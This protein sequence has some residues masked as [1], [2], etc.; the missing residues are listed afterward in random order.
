M[1]IP[2][3]D[4]LRSAENS[5]IRLEVIKGATVW[6]TSPVF[7]HQQT[8]KRI[9]ASLEPLPDSSC[10]CIETQDTYFKFPDGSLKRPDIAILCAVPPLEVQNDPLEIIPAAVVEVI[11]KIT[12]TSIIG[13]TKKMKIKAIRLGAILFSMLVTT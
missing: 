13:L 2:F 12:N 1:P 9:V 11:S 6:E 4:A 5:N 10:A 3:E 7:F 8:V